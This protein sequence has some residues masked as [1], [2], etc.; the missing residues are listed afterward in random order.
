MSTRRTEILERAS[1]VI[2]QRGFGA[3]TIADILKAASVGRGNFYHYFTNKEDLGL[4]IIDD[5]SHRVGGVEYDEVFS[6][7]KPPLVRLGDY[8]EIVRRSCR[9]GRAGDPLCTLASELG[10]TPPYATRLRMALGSLIDR[11][12]ALVSEYSREIG[13]SMH[14]QVYA[15]AIV[16][17]THG[18]CAQFKV[19]GFGEIFDE[20]IAA[21]PGLLTSAAL[22]APAMS[23]RQSAAH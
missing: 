1:G 9:H 11:I 2:Y 16:A 20:G 8:L 21:I 15:R 4:S 6:P 12:E 5:L 13:V 19:D 23:T 10:A 3:A 17:Q 22:T 14:P 18:L 7:M